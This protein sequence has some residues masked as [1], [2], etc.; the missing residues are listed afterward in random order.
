PADDALHGRGGPNGRPDRDHRQ[1]QDPRVRYAGQPEADDPHGDDLPA[2]GG[3]DARHGDVLHD[4]GRQELLPHGRYLEGP[5]EPHVH[6]GRRRSGGG[7]LERHHVPRQ[8]GPFVAEIRADPGG[9]VHQHGREGIRMKP[10]TLRRTDLRYR[11]GLNLRAVVGRSYPRIVGANREPSWIFFEALLPLLGIAA[12]VFIY[13]AFGTRAIAAILGSSSTAPWGM[14]G[15]APCADAAQQAA[16]LAMAKA[17]TNAL[18]A[19]VVLGGTMVAFWLNVLWSM[20]SQLYWEKEIGNL[21]LYM[22]APMN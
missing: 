20:A 9:C 18:I 3:H 2:R 7:D 19:S 21:Q 1:R 15:Q 5:D 11:I 16:Y 4:A 14:C 10:A 8:E 17:N 22:M 13:Q 6:P 12:Y